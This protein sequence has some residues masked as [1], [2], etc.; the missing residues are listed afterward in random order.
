ML[1]IALGPY[2]VIIS[3]SSTA[4]ILLT[5]NCIVFATTGHAR[6][7]YARVL[8]NKTRAI[9]GTAVFQVL[10]MQ[11]VMRYTS[12]YVRSCSTVDFQ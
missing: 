1:E 11:S 4:R 12:M 7:E 5:E 9:S 2:L 8:N 6:F 10:A 3:F